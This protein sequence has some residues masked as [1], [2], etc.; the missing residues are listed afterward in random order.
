MKVE[1]ISINNGD[2]S[3]L[4]IKVNGKS[5]FCVSSGEPE[6]ANLNRDFN[7]CYKITNLMKV[8]WEAGK[9]GEP[10]EHSLVGKEGD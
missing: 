7:D 1:E 8:A 3:E 2:W 6:D 9:A 10:F 4:E 5:E